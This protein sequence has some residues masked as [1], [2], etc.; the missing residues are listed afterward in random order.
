MP[1]IIRFSVILCL[2]T[3]VI[4][5]C[6]K[7][8]EKNAQETAKD[9]AM[10]LYTV[11]MKEVENYKSLL[12][13]HTFDSKL[14]TEAIQIN[15]E[16]L[17]SLM[18]DDAYETLLKNRDNLKFTEICYRKNHTIQVTEIQLSENKTDIENND[19]AGYNFEIQLKLI[20]NDGTE[21]VGIGKGSIELRRVD[22]NWKVTGYRYIFPDL[23]REL[24]NQ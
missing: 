12:N 3:L 9:F 4:V 11:D 14:F 8:E 19:E 1:R 5:G 7:N 16:I 17:K 18:T 22:G 15:D 2:M 13:L 6:S 23:L 10:D 21:T 20:S 24:L